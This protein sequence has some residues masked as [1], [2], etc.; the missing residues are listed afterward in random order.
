MK[1]MGMWISVGLLGLGVVA[2]RH[3]EQ[4]APLQDGTP[5]RRVR[6]APGSG[7]TL[8]TPETREAAQAEVDP[9]HAAALRVAMDQRR[10]EHDEQIRQHRKEVVENAKRKHEENQR[11]LAEHRAQRAAWEAKRPA[12]PARPRPEIIRAEPQPPQPLEQYR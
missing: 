6:L 3:K 5:E 9:E 11:R 2:L 4:A 8:P 7:P 1:R 10:A 12:D